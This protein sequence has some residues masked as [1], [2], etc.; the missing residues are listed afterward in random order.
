MLIW[1]RLHSTQWTDDSTTDLSPGVPRSTHRP[2][3]FSW[4]WW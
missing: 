2:H 1:R 4:G 3:W